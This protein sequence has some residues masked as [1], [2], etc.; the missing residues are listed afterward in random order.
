MEISNT[1]GTALFALQQALEQPQNL[2]DLMA[3]S[4]VDS[5]QSL[6]APSGNAE[7]QKTVAGQSGKGSII[8]IM[9]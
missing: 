3:K 6:A 4:N 9:A 8:N 5:T 2:V 7:L 1:G